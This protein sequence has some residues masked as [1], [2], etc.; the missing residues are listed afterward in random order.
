TRLVDFAARC[1]M[2]TLVIIAFIGLSAQLIDGGLGMGYGVVSSSLLLA[3]G[4]SPAAAS[5]SVHLAEIGTTFAS[6]VSHWRFGNIDWPVVAKLALPGAVGAF[7][8]ATLLA[9][10]PADDAKP[11]TSGILLVLGA[12]ILLRF[13]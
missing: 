6:G 3:A 1:L 7:L 9:S 2:P 10:L 12:Y 5:A 4:L 13:S 8:G 11:W